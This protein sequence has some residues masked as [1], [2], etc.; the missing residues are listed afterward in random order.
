MRLKNSTG[1]YGK[2]VWWFLKKLKIDLDL[3]YDLVIPL[4]GIYPKTS[5][6]GTQRNICLLVYK[7]LYTIAKRWKQ[8][9]CTLMDEWINKIWYI[10]M[11]EYYSALKRKEANTYYIMDDPVGHYAK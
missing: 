10:H 9:Q 2:K 4:P 3:P 6:V 7:A 11:M 5:K 1:Y 8:P